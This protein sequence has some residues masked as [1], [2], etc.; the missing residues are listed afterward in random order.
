[1]ILTVIFFCKQV[2][3]QLSTT[4]D[5]SAYTK[6]CGVTAGIVPKGLRIEWSTRDNK[7]NRLVLNAEQQKNIIREFSL[8]N[9]K[10][11]PFEAITK[12]ATP[13]FIVSVGKRDMTYGWNIFFDNVYRKPYETY[14]LQWHITRIKVSSEGNRCYITI[15][16]VFAGPFTGALKFTVYNNSN[17]VYVEAVL[18]S[19]KN[20]QAIVYDAG[21]TSSNPGW[22]NISWLDNTE[23]WQQQ[24]FN[25]NADAS[26]IAVKY[27][28]V[29][30][31]GNS[32]TM[33]IF[34]SPHQYFYP[35]DFTENYKFN[36][37]GKNY[38]D[39]INQYGIGIRLPLNGDERYV[40][41][42]NAPPDTKQHLDFFILISDT[43]AQATLEEVKRYTRNDHYEKLEGYTTFS[44]HYHIEH[45]MDVVNSRVQP[46]GTDDENIKQKEALLSP[47]FVKTFKELGIDIVHLGE[48]H[49]GETPGL[50]AKDRLPL[51]QLLHKECERL[52]DNDFL[53]LPGEE[54][55]VYFG[56]HWLSFFPKPV[57]WILNRTGNLPFVQDDPVYGKVYHIGSKED[58][59]ELLKRENGLAWTAHPRI[60]S[61]FGFP[62]RY[63]KEP[64]YLSDRF[65]GGAWKNMPGDLSLDRLGTRVLD[66]ANDM[67][68]W[69]QRKYVFGEVDVFKVQPSHEQY[70]HSNVNYLRLG[71]KIN[72]RDGWQPVLDALQTGSFFTTTGEV[73]IK[74]FTLNGKRSGE[75][76]KL[77][78]PF[79][80]TA[81]IDIAWTFP[82]S[83]AEIVYGDG[84]K[85]YRKRV[86][87]SNT[88]SFGSKHLQYSINLKGQKWAR[89]EVW[90]V[91]KNGAFTPPVWLE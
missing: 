79:L 1:M 18:S 44:S 32:G 59:L 11:G 72:F 67:A 25:E 52:S 64:F 12:D 33:A 88:N 63:N 6:N 85:T 91:A 35:L 28:T 22:K 65:L 73:L 83:F 24:V 74:E 47:G 41:W 21:L 37:F 31:G 39:H 69:G 48:F 54:P 80:V 36:W 75:E 7:R 19:A 17:L 16:S 86:E 76:L 23:N 38:R 78:A 15:D 53:L 62:D 66:L 20:A 42:F 81:D 90:D 14:R 10:G 3:G 27:R 4:I 84:E 50:T 82:L 30:A 51:L 9:K 89:V 56:G 2:V 40:P 34:P 29:M 5:F 71:K 60:K 77:D 43:N 26:P 13:V 61:S 68:N 49:L 8:Q 45:T 70:G 57:Y 55:N 87:L 46:K 58:M